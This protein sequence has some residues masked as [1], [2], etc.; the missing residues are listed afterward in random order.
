MGGG[1]DEVGEGGMRWREGGMRWREGGRR[2]RE[3]GNGGGEGGGR[4]NDGWE[5]RKGEKWR[6][7]DKKGRME[8][9]K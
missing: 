1:R 5:V 4:R 8:K 2:W 3:V 6:K 7:R 9:E